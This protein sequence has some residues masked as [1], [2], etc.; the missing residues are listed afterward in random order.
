MAWFVR[1]AA[2]WEGLSAVPPEFE[3]FAL[4]PHFELRGCT[5]GPSVDQ[6]V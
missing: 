6:F 4:A 3:I 1:N 5:V 2:K